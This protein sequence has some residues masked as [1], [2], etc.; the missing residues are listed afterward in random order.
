MPQSAFLGLVIGGFHLLSPGHTVR[1]E[2]PI[3]WLLHKNTRQVSKSPPRRRRRS[4]QLHVHYQDSF[5]CSLESTDFLGLLGKNGEKRETAEDRDV[6]SFSLFPSCFLLLF[7]KT[8]ILSF[9]AIY[10]G[11]K[12]K[13]SV[14][15]VEAT[16]LSKTVH[17]EGKN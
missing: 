12:R 5:C 4:V 11:E 2:E 7:A 16:I 8:I 13:K 14:A 6:V 3:A 15:P 17:R 1:S 9:V 10:F